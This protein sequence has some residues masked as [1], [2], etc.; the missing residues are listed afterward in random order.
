MDPASLA[1]AEALACGGVPDIAGRVAATF[2]SI[3]DFSS[4][5]PP[6]PI[7]TA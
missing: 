5:D 7:A 1:A 3:L 6:F 4:F 2:S